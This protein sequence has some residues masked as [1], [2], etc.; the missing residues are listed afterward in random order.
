MTVLGK[1]D[2]SDRDWKVESAGDNYHVTDMGTGETSSISMNNFEFE[3]NSL[4]KM[5]VDTHQ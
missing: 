3:H 2:D 4:I 5:D 1:G